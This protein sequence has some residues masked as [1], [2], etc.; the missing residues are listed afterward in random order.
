MPYNGRRWLPQG[1]LP[2]PPHSP[3]FGNTTAYI[4][5]TH[6]GPPLRA[7]GSEGSTA[8]LRLDRIK[9]IVD[10]ATQFKEQ[11]FKIMENPIPEGVLASKSL[12]PLL[13]RAVEK[14]DPQK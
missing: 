8:S 5:I 10:F 4:R 13:I 3:S 7:S 9:R 14:S 11:S 2:I 12:V 1:V 6:S